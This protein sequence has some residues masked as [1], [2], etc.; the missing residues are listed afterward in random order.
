MT[1]NIDVRDNTGKCL[2]KNTEL[3]CKYT[4]KSCFAPGF[5]NNL[6]KLR[7]DFNAPMIITSACRSATYNKQV[8]GSPRSF[9]VYDKPYWPTG[10]CAAIDVA[11][12]NPNQKTK[13]IGL[14]LKQGWSIGVAKSF[15]HLD[16][17]SDYTLLSQSVFGY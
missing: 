6:K 9:H 4:Y 11:V 15:I 16:R 17:R 3:M 12:R 1:H 7:C 5:L 2:F 14:A 10:G 8:G 13:L